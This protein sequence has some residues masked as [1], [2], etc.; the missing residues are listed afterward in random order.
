MAFGCKI[1]HAIGL[2]FEID[3]AHTRRVGNVSLVEFDPAG[4]FKI[5]D[6][7]AIRV[8]GNFV[9]TRDIVRRMVFRD[10]VDEI[11]ADKT[12]HAGDKNIHK[13]SVRT[14]NIS[15]LERGC[16]EG[17]KYLVQPI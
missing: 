16:R 11:C 7:G 14:F 9:D 3:L 2:V 17:E 5:G 4:I 12:G 10:E 1:Y 15:P 13:A 8:V 6:V